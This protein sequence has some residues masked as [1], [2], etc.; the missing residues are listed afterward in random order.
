ML[1]KDANVP[2]MAELTIPRDKKIPLFKIV[3]SVKSKISL[4][5]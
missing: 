3:S 5:L 2:K 4:Y 1:L